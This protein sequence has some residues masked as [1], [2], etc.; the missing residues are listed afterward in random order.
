MAHHVACANLS[1]ADQKVEML[2]DGLDTGRVAERKVVAAQVDHGEERA[3]DGDG[4]RKQ[5]SRVEKT[6]PQ[7]GVKLLAQRHQVTQLRATGLGG[8]AFVIA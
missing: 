7:R 4:S 1:L 5:L 6:E 3:E 2:C 8:Q